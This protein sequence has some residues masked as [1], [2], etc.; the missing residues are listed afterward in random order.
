MNEHD[1]ERM[2]GILGT[3]GFIEVDEPKKQIL[4][5]LIPVQ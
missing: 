2:L 1:S 5:F 3:K 4:L